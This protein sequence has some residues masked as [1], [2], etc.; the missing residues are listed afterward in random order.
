VLT[1]FAG[2]AESLWDDALPVEVRELPEDPAA[3]R[4]APRAGGELAIDPATVRELLGNPRIVLTPVQ[5]ADLQAG[6]IDPRL[7]ATLAAIGRRHTVVITALQSDHYPGPT[8][9]PAARW[10][11]AP[12]T[13]SDATAGAPARAR[14]SCANSRRSRGRCVRPS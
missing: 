7:V 14:N 11:S 2:Q 5:R 10:T 6:D 3:Y 1:R 4:D 9:R 8:T 12:S 13:A